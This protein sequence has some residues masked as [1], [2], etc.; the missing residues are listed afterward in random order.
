M[1]N[2]TYYFVGIKGTG[3]ASLATIMHG[4]G[5]E[6]YGSDIPKHFF[7]EDRLREL[8][9]PIYDFLEAPIA[10]GTTIIVGNA[11]LEDHE[12]VQRVRTFENVEILRYHEFL[13]KLMHQYR[14]I[15]VSGS[16]GKTTT[17]TLLKD[18][19]QE[20]TTAGYLIGDGQG[21]V[22]GADEYFAVE[23][24]EYR[25]HF[26][27]YHPAVAIMTNFE[28]DHVDYFKSNE[29]YLQAFE[30]F[31][32]NVQ[33]LVIAWGDDVNYSSL[34]LGPKVWTY[35][36]GDG[37]TL[38][39]LITKETSQYTEFDVLFEGKKVYCFHLPL[40]GH[41]LILDALSVI[42]VG[43]YEGIAYIDI[44]KGLQN[45]KGAKRRYV[46]EDEGAN[47]FID[48][49][50]HH[51]TEVKVTLEATR[52]RFPNHKVVAIFKPHRVGRVF[53][54][55]DEFAS[56]L[57]IADEVALCP[58]TSIDD[59]EDGIDIDITYLQDKIPRSIIVEEIEEDIDALASFAPAV[60]VFMSSKDIYDLKDA[61]KEKLNY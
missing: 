37:N 5:N 10:E 61:V 53:K 22:G 50:A 12:E 8:H 33:E 13:G 38:Q 2:N 16:H 36:F 44:E 46:V 11:F 26:L 60:F 43:I 39:A 23:A 48:D 14:S 31:A 28:I 20:S 34:D 59:Q 52:K 17:T 41:H 21:H 45:F 32:K 7:P 1:K 3:M 57:S 54:F 51:P 56:A 58:F 35:G 15:A 19:L 49:Y 6:V 30:E 24:C 25:H 40:V 18:M 47:V 9:I 29:E 27:A 42:G 55:G 4:L